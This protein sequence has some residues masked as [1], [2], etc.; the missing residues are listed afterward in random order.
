MPV[1]SGSITHSAAT[2]ATAASAAVPPSRSA[3]MA[4][5]VASGCEVAAMPSQAMTG[6]RP[7]SWK[8]RLMRCGA[9]DVRQR[10]LDGEIALRRTQGDREAAEHI[11]EADNE[12]QKECRGRA[13][14]HQ[15]EFYQH[16]KKQNERQPVIDD[17]TNTDARRLHHLAE[18]H[19]DRSEA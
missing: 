19:Q 15:Q 10:A 9:S 17:G 16:A 11:N 18:Q 1:L 4:A 6:E 8:S 5:S 2:A 12:Q 7:G 14:L 13:L 3:S